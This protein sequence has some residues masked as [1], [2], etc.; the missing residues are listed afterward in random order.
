MSHGDYLR[1]KNVNEERARVCELLLSEEI[2]LVEGVRRIVERSQ[3]LGFTFDDNIK[4]LEQI[5][6]QSKR[7]PLGES[8]EQF[9]DAKLRAL[10]IERQQFE[11]DN[12]DA[13][14]ECCRQ[15][16]RQMPG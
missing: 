4:F 5:D 16:L 9:D 8:R 11:S 3:F 2:G 7:F 15:I 14:Y 13:V 6:F 1:E 12:R 10:D